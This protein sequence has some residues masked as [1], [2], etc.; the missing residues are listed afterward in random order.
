MDIIQRKGVAISDFLGSRSARAQRNA[1]LCAVIGIGL[2]AAAQLLM[3]AT[4]MTGK[5]GDVPQFLDAAWRINHGQIPHVDFYSHLGSLPYYITW[6]GMKISGPNTGAISSGNVCFMLIASGLTFLLLRRRTSGFFTF[7]FTVFVA[8]LATAPRPLGDPY[9]FNDYAMLYNRQGEALLLALVVGVMIRPPSESKS[10]S[11]ADAVC[12]G[13]LW[14]CLLW[15]KLS[16]FTVA[17]GLIVCAVPLQTLT[18]RNALILGASAVLWSAIYLLA[19]GIPVSAFSADMGIMADAQDFSG[20]IKVVAIQL[21]KHVHMLP[22]LLLLAW[23]A[24][25]ALRRSGQHPI[26][27]VVP[28]L[29]LAG[30]ALLMLSSNAQRTDLPLLAVVC[31]VGVEHVRRSETVVPA[32]QIKPIPIIGASVI[33]IIYLLPILL[34]D[35]NAFRNA[36]F[37]KIQHKQTAA[38]LQRTQLSDFIMMADGETAGTISNYQDRLI[39]GLNLI[40]RQA[41]GL[42]IRP[43]VFANPFEFALGLPP[44]RGGAICIAYNTLNAKSHPSFARIVGDATHVMVAKDGPEMASLFGDEL[45]AFKLLETDES[46]HFILYELSRDPPR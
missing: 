38:E 1:V 33:L 40:R 16:Y 14:Q 15:I 17:A 43:L 4:V 31:L 27:A 21:F 37:N 5:P 35:A 29:L 42:K 18:F 28:M 9:F 11:V 26:H 36:A 20:K 19:T 24:M 12:C 45:N 3:G 6:F 22:L 7:L 34:A 39:S 2:L 30:S 46:E 44:S 23:E 41:P 32:D 10:W 8:F 25:N 13:F